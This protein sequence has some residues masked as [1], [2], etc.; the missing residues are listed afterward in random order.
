ME[1]DLSNIDLRILYPEE[2]GE[3]IYLKDIDPEIIEQMEDNKFYDEDETPTLMSEIEK[4]NNAQKKILRE[5][6]LIQARMD[7]PPHYNPLDLKTL[8]GRSYYFVSES[9]YNQPNSLN[10]NSF[11]K[12]FG[13]NGAVT[14]VMH[15]DRFYLCA[16]N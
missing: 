5:I 7:L 10:V 1:R 14:A 12:R 11:R 6:K 3:M 4:L 16:F 15:N 13:L 2:F 9:M 8:S